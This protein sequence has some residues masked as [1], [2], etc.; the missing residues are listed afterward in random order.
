MDRNLKQNTA[1]MTAA[2]LGILLLGMLI[3]AASWMK[4]DALVFPGV[5]RI[6]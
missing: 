5:P 1:K 6:L 3:Q 2:V 4:G